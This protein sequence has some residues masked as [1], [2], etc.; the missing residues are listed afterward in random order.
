MK[1]LNVL[2]IFSILS[3]VGCSSPSPN[4]QPRDKFG[5]LFPD[6]IGIATMES[7]YRTAPRYVP[8]ASQIGMFPQI[9]LRRLEFFDEQTCSVTE[10]MRAYGSMQ[11]RDLN[12]LTDFCLRQQVAS[13]AEPIK[14]QA[15][16]QSIDVFF[17]TDR[18]ELRDG[19]ILGF[20][21]ERGSFSVGLV[22]VSIPREHKLGAVE[23]RSSST[24]WPR[25]SEDGFEILSIRLQ[26]QQSFFQQTK[27]QLQNSKERRAFIFV[28]GYNVSF[29]D[30][31]LRTAQL[32]LDLDPEALPVFF[33]WPSQG[34]MQAYPVDSQNAEWTE[35]NLQKF[36]ETFGS[37]SGAESIVVI[38][39][40]MGS[41]PAMRALAKVLDKRRDLRS[42]FKELVLAAP[43]IDADVFVRD[44]VPA[45]VALRMPVTLYASAKDK[46]LQLSKQFNGSPRAG[47]ANPRPPVIAGIE[48]VDA[49]DIDTDFLGH[50]YVAETRALLTDVTLLIKN[51]LRATDRPGLLKVDAG[52]GLSFWR[53]KK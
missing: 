8:G 9:A 11:A 42:K 15:T 46:A 35:A 28:H 40:S 38:A 45:Y 41:R 43:D 37:T 13:K 26:G 24:L 27:E 21:N 34:A 39:H 29:A 50:A 30:A 36:L 22:K 49:T 14:G 12:A 53:F 19:A 18:K 2:L 1:S 51:R 20:G 17:A 47:D 33:S 4:I 5:L 7:A 52:A 31:A 16:Q 25:R 6:S 23:R 32:A 3:L 48:T 44:L 10:P